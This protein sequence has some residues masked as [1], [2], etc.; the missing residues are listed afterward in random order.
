MTGEDV[1]KRVWNAVAY[2]SEASRLP[3][4]MNCVADLADEVAAH[5]QHLAVNR[6][7]HDTIVARIE[8]LERTAERIDGAQEGAADHCG[9]CQES[10]HKA[11]VRL[12]GRIEALE[13][14]EAYNREARERLRAMEKRTEALEQKVKKAEHALADRDHDYRAEPHHD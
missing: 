3:A 9:D 5:E 1:R 11:R 13:K 2:G 6:R 10:E 8:A 14:D 12:Q 7:C 4:L